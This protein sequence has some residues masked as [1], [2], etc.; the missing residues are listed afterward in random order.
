MALACQVPTVPDW[1]TRGAMIPI[2]RIY[3]AVHGVTL[4]PKLP[5]V[6]RPFCWG[7]SSEELIARLAG[8]L[9]VPVPRFTTT[10][11]V[12][13]EASCEEV[14]PW[15]VQMG[16]GR[17]G[18]YGYGRSARLLGIDISGVDRIHAE[19]QR[20]TVGDP[21]RIVPEGWRGREAGSVPIYVVASILTARHL[22]LRQVVPKT[23]KPP[24]ALE[25]SWAF[26]LCAL[27][28]RRCR[29]IV[30]RRIVTKTRRGA[31]LVLLRAPLDWIIER[32]ILLGI[33]A[34]AER[35]ARRGYGTVLPH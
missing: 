20:L 10:R 16:E 23:G 18:L 3:D 21:V 8:D 19:W 35:R 12:T 9:V 30:R 28:T 25:G 33:K 29:L 26:V 5:G 34:R 31:I 2:D 1:E 24:A 13:I 6:L 7:A 27:D 11:A 4:T 17:G 22:V 15:L 14:W 32:K